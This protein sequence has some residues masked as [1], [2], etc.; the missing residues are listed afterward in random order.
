MSK[1]DEAVMDALVERINRIEYKIDKL[2]AQTQEIVS[3]SEDITFS[4][5]D[6]DLPLVSSFTEEEWPEFLVETEKNWDEFFDSIPPGDV[7]LFEDDK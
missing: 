1:Y 7:N 4:M 6:A 5:G 3:R 2:Y